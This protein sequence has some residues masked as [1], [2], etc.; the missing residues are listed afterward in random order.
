MVKSAARSKFGFAAGQLPSR[1]HALVALI[2]SRILIDV[3]PNSVLSHEL[4][5]KHFA[6]VTDLSKGREFANITYASKPIVA[7]TVATLLETYFMDAL[8][9]FITA[10]N[11]V[12]LMLDKD[13]SSFPELL[14]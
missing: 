8:K 10:I 2:C 14:S 7:E 11:L 13:P 3:R 9:E 1:H 4:M 12:S 5:A 6:L